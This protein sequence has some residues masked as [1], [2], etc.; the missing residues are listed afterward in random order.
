MT[1]YRLTRCHPPLAEYSGR[2]YM[3]TSYT[4]TIMNRITFIWWQG[5]ILAGVLSALAFGGL[6]S[7]ISSQFIEITIPALYRFEPNTLRGMLV[8]LFHGTVLGLTFAAIV[9]RSPVMAY[10]TAEP[11]LYRVG[12]RVKTVMLGIVFG[13]FVWGDTAGNCNA[14]MAWGD[15]GS[16][17]SSSVYRRREPCRSRII[18]CLA[19]AYVR[20]SGDSMMRGAVKQPSH[21]R[22]APITSS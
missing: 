21:I 7:I 13:H 4:T 2:V 3:D 12:Y 6:M 11:T 18:W 16:R 14:G 1:H 19:R 10:L 22:L 17:P 5:G 15:G 9:S 20:C 8:H